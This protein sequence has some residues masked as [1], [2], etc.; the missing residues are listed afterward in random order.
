MKTSLK[1]DFDELAKL[2]ASEH[3]SLFISDAFNALE[4]LRELGY[5]IVKQSVL[6]QRGI[7]L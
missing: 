5:V 1:P 3:E 2:M 7:E 4:V 6:D